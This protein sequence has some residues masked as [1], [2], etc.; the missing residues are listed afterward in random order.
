[1]KLTLLFLL[2]VPAYVAAQDLSGYWKGAIALP[3][4]KLGI[5]IDLSSESNGWT[6]TI[7]I[8]AQGLREYALSDLKVDGQRV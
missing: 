3:N 1:M 4:A 5:A 2:L 6:G 7:D 8:P